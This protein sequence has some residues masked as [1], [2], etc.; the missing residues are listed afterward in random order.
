MAFNELTAARF[1]FAFAGPSR[2]VLFFYAVSRLVLLFTRQTSLLKSLVECEKK[3]EVSVFAPCMWAMR[4]CVILVLLFEGVLA[5][6]QPPEKIQRFSLLF[7][8]CG[9]R[10]NQLKRGNCVLD[11]IQ[12]YTRRDHDFSKI[13]PLV[14]FL[15][16]F[17]QLTI[18]KSHAVPNKQKT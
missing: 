7:F 14:R 18:R 10:R 17:S 16:H 12:L 13:K 4:A 6:F 8:Q 15:S 9:G 3:N 11:T 5:A 1:V 2:V